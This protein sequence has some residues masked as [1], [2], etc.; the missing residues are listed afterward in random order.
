MFIDY[1]EILVQAGDGGNGCVS[2]RREKYVP[3]GG[4][5]GGDGG[6]GGDVII[7]VNPNLS[8]LI[9]L[10]YRKV[11]KAQRG[12]NGEGGNRSGIRGEDIII[13]VPQGTIVKDLQENKILADLTSGNDSIIVVYR[14]RGGKGN[15]HFKSSTNRTPRKAE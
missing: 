5:D 11:Y 7:R 15:S 4:P 1:I 10:R 3:K 2:F 13:N 8:T 9:D 14:G 6:D 12:G